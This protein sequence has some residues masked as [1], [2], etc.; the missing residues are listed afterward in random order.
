MLGFMVMPKYSC[1]LEDYL[2]NVG[3]N[4]PGFIMKMG[5][6]LVDAFEIVH[7]CG[8]TYNDVKPEN[9]MVETDKEGHR[10]I[11]L[12]DF[13]L[14]DRYIDNEKNHVAEHKEKES[15]QGNIL[16]SSLN[17]MNFK[18]ASRKD[19]LTA[20]AYMMLYI[21]NDN[22]LPGLSKSLFLSINDTNDT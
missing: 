17:Q 14:A 22:S 16:F 9:V 3:N 19:D 15:F 11:V 7:Q 18:V 12:I 5:L 1:D 13:G 10:H 2:K 21:L 6:Q 8:R 20:L 4:D